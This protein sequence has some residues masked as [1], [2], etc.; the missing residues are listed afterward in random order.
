[1][2]QPSIFATT[3]GIPFVEIIYEHKQVSLFRLLDLPEVGISVN[4]ISIEQL[5]SKI[6]LVWTQRTE[7]TGKL[8]KRCEAIKATNGQACTV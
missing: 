3:L 5:L 2:M 8:T 7:I 1:M 6:H 4:N